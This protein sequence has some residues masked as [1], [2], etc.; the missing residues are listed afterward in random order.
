MTLP[1]PHAPV[2][3]DL[4]ARHAAE[5]DRYDQHY[6]E[7]WVGDDLVL[8]E[9]H[10]ERPNDLRRATLYA[11]ERLGDLHGL[12]VLELGAGSGVDSIMLARLGANVTATDIAAASVEL[13]ERRFG[14]NEISGAQMAAMPAEELSLPDASFDRIFARGVLHHADVARAAPE[15][16]RVLR[17]GGRAVFI[18]PLSENPVLD[19]AR[20]HVPYPHKTRPKGHRGIRYATIRTLGESFAST[21]IK[22]MY[23][24]S[25]LNR[26]FGFGVELHALQDFDDWLLGRVP[27]FGRLC[28]Y[29][30][31]TCVR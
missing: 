12:D 13:I 10:Q 4:D 1:T 14:A 18:E 15:M 8:P 30:V 5:R 23:L 27:T 2:A 3:A 16:A 28:R 9:R 19:F 29:V 11:L 25:M 31:V 20:E 17:P 6:T 7:R 24:T 22:P 21:S 26:A